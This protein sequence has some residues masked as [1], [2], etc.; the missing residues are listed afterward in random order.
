MQQRKN[1]IFKKMKV[2]KFAAIHMHKTWRKEKRE[3][4][5]TCKKETKT[6][7]SY[8]V[9]FSCRKTHKPDVHHVVPSKTH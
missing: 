2:L 6:K 8:D 4:L 5:W 7:K 3:T 9:C 1:Y